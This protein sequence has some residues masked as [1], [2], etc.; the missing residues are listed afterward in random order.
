MYLKD[1]AA[2]IGTS[3]ESPRSREVLGGYRL[4][5]S[6][7]E[8]EWTKETLHYLSSREQGLQVGIDPD[9][10]IRSVFIF[11]GTREGFSP[12][13]GELGP[14]VTVKSGRGGI[15]DLF[16]PPTESGFDYHGFFSASQGNWD[17]YDFETVSAHFQYDEKTGDIELITLVRRGVRENTAG[18]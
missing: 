10:T 13:P 7:L 4:S 2:I 11:G 14:G 1:M 9:K 6:S 12:F 5:S 16:G 18:N 15:L 3:I 8:G 17:R